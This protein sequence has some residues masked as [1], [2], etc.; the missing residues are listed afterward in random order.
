[1]RILYGLGPTLLTTILLAS[2]AAYAQG[3]TEDQ[4]AVWAAV[5][6]IWEAE[7]RADN[8]AIDAMLSAD[9]MGWTAA[10]PAPTSKSSSRMWREFG[11]QQSKNLRH[12]LYP[13]SI[14]VHADMAVAHYLYTNAVQA[15]DKSV[16]VVNGRFT[17]ILVRGEETW[18][19]ISWHGGDDS[20]DD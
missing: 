9:F 2:A 1:M 11:Q 16:E 8:D 5:E 3:S 12:E 18:K 20:S 13:L 15:R 14:V 17:D 19:F 6:A 10:S 7:E 4:A